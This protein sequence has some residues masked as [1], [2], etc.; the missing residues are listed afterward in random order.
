MSASAIAPGGA[1]PTSRRFT[2]R[3]F[4]SVGDSA[5]TVAVVVVAALVLVPLFRWGVIDA[6]WTG[7]AADCRLEGRGACWAFVSQKLSFLLFGL[8][9]PAERWRAA[10]AAVAVL[11]LVGWSA[12]PRHWKRSLVAV[13]LLVLAL[14]FWLMRGGFGLPP[15]AARLWGG[16]PI[17]LMLTVIGLAVGL[18]LAIG[19]ALG[20]MAANPIARGVSSTLVEV[21]RGI[22]LVAVLYV[23]ALVVPLLLPRGVEIHK[24]VLGQLGVA[25]FAAAYLAEAV[26]S[27]L[28]MI[29]RGQREA[30]RALGLPWWTST[31]RV[32]LPQALRVVVPSLVSIAV[33]FFQDTSLVVIIGIFDLLNTARLAAQDP[34]WLGFHREAF[35]F[36]GALYF[37]G[38]AAMSRYGLWLERRLAPGTIIRRRA[39][40]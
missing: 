15:V 11:A 31:R 23:A 26:R 21:V 33:G 37:A 13:W 25:I 30:A 20:R 36:V 22:P 28:Q 3:A 39:G 38:S 17:T 12:H 18:P 1:V 35:L 40:P 19:L 8:F 4:G 2:A 9:P 29:P 10:C 16:L 14:A 27:G 6:T 32:I 5:V 34:A 7:T 24:L